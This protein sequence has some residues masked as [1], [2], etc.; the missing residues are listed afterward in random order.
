MGNTTSLRER[1][2]AKTKKDILEAYSRI[3]KKNKGAEVPVREI[4]SS[5]EISEQ[6]FFNYFPKKENLMHYYA[7]I[8]S[9]DVIYHAN[10]KKDSSCNMD[11]IKEV[12]NLS[13]RNYYRRNPYLPF[14]LIKINFDSDFLRKLKD[15]K[16]TM[17]EKEIFFPKLDGI[18]DMEAELDF[19]RIIEP[20]VAGAI[21]SGEIG[22]ANKIG[23]VVLFLKTIFW[24]SAVANSGDATDLAEI[25]KEQVN[26]YLKT[27]R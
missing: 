8:W 26:Q 19:C 18:E 4:C 10:I 27:L 5:A 17:A 14:E 6:T 9:L 11:A 3:L 25:Y 23:D 13:A 15:R 1:K 22:K 2:S 21:K 12:F 20:F 24:G 7:K 16:I